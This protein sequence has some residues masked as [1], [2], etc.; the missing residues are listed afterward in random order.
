MGRGAV[1]GPL[2]ALAL[3]AAGCGGG[4]NA[5]AGSRDAGGGASR[6][7]DPR[8]TPFVN[9]LVRT[10]DGTFLLTTNKG[11]WRVAPDGSRVEQVRDAVAVAK[12]GTSPVGT[13][14]EIADV[15]TGDLLG[16][17]HPDDPEALPEYLGIMRSIDGG[18]R[19][20]VVSRL[21][22][23]D[24][25]VIRRNGSTMYLWDAVLGAV[26]VSEDGLRSFKE[27]F[28]PRQLVLDMVVDPQ[29]PDYLLISTEEELFRST[30]QGET[31]RPS[32]QVRS[33]RM[34]WAPSGELFR[35]LEDGTFEQSADRGQTWRRVGELPAAP[36][37]IELQDA[38]TM[39]VA[40]ADGSIAETHDGGRTW[41]LLFE[42]PAA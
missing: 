31:W 38:R 21:G 8:T 16:S 4:G 12:G 39:W 29:D 15:G 24:I 27:H 30:D 28:T 33:A 40:L 34:A 23:A 19:W 3:G 2:V 7:V 22:T 9:A 20:N 36:Q 1:L 6:L 17:G 41:R 11:F 18:R 10:G 42:A 26:L 32:G 5:D 35:A 13:F 14:L 37:R 25:H